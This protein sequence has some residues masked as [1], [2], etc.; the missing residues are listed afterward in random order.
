MCL[1][2][3]ERLRLAI[4]LRHVDTVFQNHSGLIKLACLHEPHAVQD[5]HPCVLLR[6]FSLAALVNVEMLSGCHADSLLIFPLLGQQR[7]L[8]EIAVVALLQK[9]GI[10]LIYSQPRLNAGI[11]VFQQLLVFKQQTGILPA[12]FQRLLHAA[13]GFFSVVRLVKP[14]ERQIAPR[15]AM[16]RI[17]RGAP[18][19]A[20]RR[21]GVAEAVIVEASEIILGIR[22]FCTC[23]RG[24]AQYGNILHI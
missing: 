10:T 19:K 5:M 9:L 13:K 2:I 4:R 21:L 16:R 7:Q 12:V 6:Q 8:I 3:E 24:I 14:V 15:G 17:F 22:R 18:C 20:V 23:L 11:G 1:L